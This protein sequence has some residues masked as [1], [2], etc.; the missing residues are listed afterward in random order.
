MGGGG[1]SVCVGGGGGQLSL[2]APNENCSRQPDDTNLFFTF[3]F[4][5]I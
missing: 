4:K 2:K 1:G 3:I 5:R